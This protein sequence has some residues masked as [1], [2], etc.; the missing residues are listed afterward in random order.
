MNDANTLALALDPTNI[1]L[2][3]GLT[4]DPW[5]RELLLST[6]PAILLN[7]SRGAGKSRTTSALALH[8]A[9]FRPP[10][11]VLLISRSQRQAGELFR[12][13]KQGYRAV[14][15]P[16]KAVKETE[17][18]LELANGSRIVCLPG[19]EETIRSY[20][21]VNLLVLDEAAR[22]PDELYASVSPMTGVSQGR[23]ICLSTPFGQRGWWWREW[24]SPSAS[25]Q[26]FLIK[27][28]SCPRLTPAFIA[29]ERRKFG[30][31]WIQQEYECSFTAMEGLVY[32]NFFEQTRTT[33]VAPPGKLVGGIDFGFR[34]PFAAIWG[35]IQDDVLHID[36]EIYVRQ[37]PLTTLLV[38]LPRNVLWAADPAGAAEIA[39]LRVAD[40][41]VLKGK[42]DIR[43]GIAAVMAR[44]QTGRL[45]VHE[46]RCPNLLAEARLYRYPSQSELATLGENPVDQDNHALAAL[47]YLVSRLD[48]HYLARY[49]RGASLPA[50][51]RTVDRAGQLG[52]QLPGGRLLKDI[53]DPA[54]WKRL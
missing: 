29:E 5:Q 24:H 6:S 12:Y 25:W 18:Q 10:S 11:L 34:N 27:W 1:L 41:K 47:R 23:T 19:T 14:G 49:R 50:D 28:D 51:E 13:V 2:A 4:P 9:L 21:G 53:N 38:Q 46:Q 30:T 36:H 15:R 37:T 20:Q 54:L 45:R 40:F 3:Q 26:R 33:V 16:V 42:N 39:Q 31:A 43:S 7:C 8:T 35:S 48:P 32:P 44:L 22:I 17:T 52:Q